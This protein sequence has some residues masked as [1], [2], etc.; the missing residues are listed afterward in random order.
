M[1]ELEQVMLRSLHSVR[2]K[3]EN[4]EY[5]RCQVTH[6]G[7]HIP[8]ARSDHAHRHP[9][10]ERGWQLWLAFPRITHQGHPHLTAH[11]KMP[12]LSAAKEPLE[13]VEHL[14]YLTEDTCGTPHVSRSSRFCD[15]SY[16]QHTQERFFFGDYSGPEIVAR[17]GLFSL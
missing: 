13:R 3:W 15:V 16:S 11:Q 12:C 14:A 17:Q 5:H 8:L 4:T 6:H 2:R 10:F 1:P 7:P 9:I